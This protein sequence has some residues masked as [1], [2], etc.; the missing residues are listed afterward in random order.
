MFIVIVV[1]ELKLIWLHSAIR[2]RYINGKS[3]VEISSL[4][5]LYQNKFQPFVCSLSDILMVA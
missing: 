1:N 3:L 4:F 5:E 2:T